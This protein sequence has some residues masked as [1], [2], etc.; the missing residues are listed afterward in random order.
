MHSGPE[1]GQELSLGNVK[2]ALDRLNLV[3]LDKFVNQ[4]GGHHGNGR[5]IPGSYRSRGLDLG[6]CIVARVAGDDFD[7]VLHGVVAFDHF[8]H[9]AGQRAL[10]RGRKIVGN[11]FRCHRRLRTG[12][13]QDCD[14]GE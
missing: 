12:E 6:L 2:E 13:K 3:F 8:P 1:I 5:W 11:L 7:L 4:V 9:F 10:H 14:E